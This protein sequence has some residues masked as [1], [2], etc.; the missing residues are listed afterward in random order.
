LSAYDNEIAI[1]QMEVAYSSLVERRTAKDAST[2]MYK[3][4]DMTSKLAKDGKSHPRIITYA[5]R[6]ILPTKLI[7]YSLISVWEEII[8]LYSPFSA[9]S[10]RFMNNPGNISRSVQSRI[11][12]GSYFYIAHEEGLITNTSIHAGIRQKFAD[13]TFIEN[14]EMVGFEIISADDIDDIG[15]KET[16]RRIR[17]RVGNT[18]VYLRFVLFPDLFL[19]AV[20]FSQFRYRRSRYAKSREH[21]IYNLLKHTIQDPSMAPASMLNQL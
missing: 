1:D 15:I 19:T 7:P 20:T 9:R 6:L 14:D 10:T 16:I 18:P 12:H 11:T 2:G 3:G 4:F 5:A 17:D 21:C 8:R 13:D